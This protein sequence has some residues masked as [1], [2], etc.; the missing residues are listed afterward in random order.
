MSEVV[1]RLNELPRLKN[2]PLLLREVSARL[3]WGMSKVLDDRQKLVAA[4]L[5]E[6]ECPFPASPIQLLVQLPEREFREVLF[7]E[8]QMS[9]EQAVRS[10]AVH[11][12]CVAVAFAS[13][14][15]GSA[16]R[17]RSQGGASVYYSQ[18]GASTPQHRDAFEA[19]LYAESLERPVFFWGDLDWS[20]MAILKAMRQSFPTLQAWPR[21]YE[22]ML[23]Q[24]LA[25]QGHTPHEADK[26]GQLPVSSTGCPYADAQLIPALRSTGAFVDQELF[27][28]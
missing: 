25:G 2:Q 10:G 1:M 28:I 11:L 9:F 12:E 20:G 14:F 8:N 6:L 23:H 17:L 5:G 13:G 3:F 4:L 21:G 7:I 24:L 18:R 26:Q 15:K 27:S 22:P 16:Q 19:W